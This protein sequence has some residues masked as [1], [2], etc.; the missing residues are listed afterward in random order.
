MVAV[1]PWDLHGARSV[2][3]TC[4]WIGRR[5]TPWPTIFERPAVTGATLSAVAQGLLDA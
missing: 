5:G 1:H 3:M 2:G 4:G